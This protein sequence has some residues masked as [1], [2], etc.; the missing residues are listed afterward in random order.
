[1]LELSIRLRQ[2][3]LSETL[4]VPRSGS[5]CI[6]TLTGTAIWTDS[7]VGQDLVAARV[8]TTGNFTVL[9]VGFSGVAL[10]VCASAANSS[11]IGTVKV[12]VA[13]GR[14]GA[15][16]IVVVRAPSSLSRWDGHGEDGQSLD[17]DCVG[18]HIQDCNSKIVVSCYFRVRS[19]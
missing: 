18:E 9:L 5:A 3:L 15:S 2:I 1:M 7:R 6:D 12:C 10:D 13:I 19:L 17:E 16:L 4:S 8:V 14:I 11:R